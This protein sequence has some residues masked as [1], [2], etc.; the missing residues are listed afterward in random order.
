MEA[1]FVFFF[2]ENDET[3]HKITKPIRIIQKLRSASAAHRK[4]RK[5]DK[6]S[7]KL[8]LDRCSRIEYFKN[9]LEDVIKTLKK[10]QKYCESC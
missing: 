9:L 2:K 10:L 5:Y 7:R 1:L 3:A 6:I 8:G 4:G